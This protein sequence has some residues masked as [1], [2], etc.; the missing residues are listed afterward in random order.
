MSDN[1]TLENIFSI[2]SKELEKFQLTAQ[3]FFS[4][5][6]SYNRIVDDISYIPTEYS[7]TMLKYQNEY[8]A[9]F[10]DNYHD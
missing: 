8:M 1:Q 9:S 7:S 2:I 5:L 3:P 4:N 6:T 10:S